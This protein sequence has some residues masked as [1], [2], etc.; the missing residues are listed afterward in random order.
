MIKTKGGIKF[1]LVKEPTPVNEK[2]DHSDE[3]AGDSVGLEPGVDRVHQ[4][5]R[6][7]VF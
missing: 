1:L 2:G 6:Q 3:R 7:W 5:G 4:L